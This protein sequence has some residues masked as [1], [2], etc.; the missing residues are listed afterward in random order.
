MS[1][2]HMLVGLRSLWMVL[3]QNTLI[4]G[5]DFMLTWKFDWLIDYSDLR[6]IRSYNQQQCDCV[7]IHKSLTN[8]M[9][10]WKDCFSWTRTLTHS[11]WPQIPQSHSDGLHH[12]WCPPQLHVC[13]GSNRGLGDR[14][15]NSMMKLICEAFRFSCSSTFL[16]VSS[17]P[18][19]PISSI[20]KVV[21]GGTW[22]IR[23][24]VCLC[25]NP[26]SPPSAA[27]PHYAAWETDHT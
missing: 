19:L 18:P 4:S 3:G 8:L 17:T 6:D 25:E 1:K 20:R 12:N 16:S 2:G 21:T 7:Y 10:N 14:V 26:R 15:L 27:W 13:N 5:P 11:Q 22:G 24:D 23:Q 9:A